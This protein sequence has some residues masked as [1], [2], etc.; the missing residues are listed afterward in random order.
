MHVLKVICSASPPSP[1]YSVYYGCNH[2]YYARNYDDTRIISMMQLC[3]PIASLAYIDSDCIGLDL[4][5]E[6]ID[7]LHSL[8]APDHCIQCIASPV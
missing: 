5:G 8:S 2:G 3:T 6:T 7:N 4:V 1:V